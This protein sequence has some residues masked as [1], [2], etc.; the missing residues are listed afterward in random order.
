MDTEIRK[1]S[2]GDLFQLVQILE[3]GESWKRLMAIIPKTLSLDNFEAK[4]AINN[5]Y[6]YNTDH[7]KYVFFCLILLYKRLVINI[8]LQINRK[9]WHKIAET[10][11]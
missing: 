7:F 2:P 5:L 4:I 6:K 1:L 8:I 10:L 9:C 11:L 3:H